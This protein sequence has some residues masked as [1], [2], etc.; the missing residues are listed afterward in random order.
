MNNNNYYTQ[1]DGKQ[2]NMVNNQLLQQMQ[3]FQ[4]TPIN[5]QIDNNPNANINN[6]S[7]NEQRYAT[8]NNDYEI[9][10][11]PTNQSER[12]IASD[13]EIDLVSDTNI[14]R[15]KAI[16]D[17]PQIPSVQHINNVQIP[18]QISNTNVVQQ[19]NQHFSRPSPNLQQNNPNLQN[20]PRHN[21]H[22]NPIQPQTNPIQQPN[23]QQPNT[24]QQIT[25]QPNTITTQ[26]PNT[27]TS[28]QPQLKPNSD[29]ILA[30]TKIA[31]VNDGQIKPP[32]NISN[33]NTNLQIPNTMSITLPNIL[34]TSSLQPTTISNDNNSTT[35]T[36]KNKQSD[37]IIMTI[38][39]F[40]LFILLV[41]PKTSAYLDK[42]I[43]PITNTRGIII[44]AG[45]LA[46]A[47]LVL[48]IVLG[49]V[50]K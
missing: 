31:G 24:Q 28:Q 25:Y 42:Y 39:L 43:P 14:V 26:Q 46:G 8:H 47:Y 36:G 23:T 27:N 5:K 13:D 41:Y 30:K 21:I 18:P 37:Y 15:S 29:D 38:F 17:K 16:Y 6:I 32:Q 7:Q 40:I 34:P 22:P 49:F 45:I 33:N 35:I 11:H 44:R 9:A 10:P 12:L 4:G 20:N 2:Y 3:N 1:L 48:K 50:S 19:N